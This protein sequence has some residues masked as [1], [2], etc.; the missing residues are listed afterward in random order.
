[1]ARETGL[2][3]RDPRANYPK[4][5]TPGERPLFVEILRVF[6]TRIRI[7]VAVVVLVLAV[8]VYQ[9]MRATPIYRST[10]QILVERQHSR[11][12]QLNDPLEVDTYDN[13]YYTTQYKIL[14]GPGLARQVAEYLTAK[15]METDEGDV[16]GGLEIT[17]LRNNRIFDVAYYHS[18]P[19][20]AAAVANAVVECYTAGTKRRRLDTI[21]DLR[22]EMTGELAPL[23]QKLDDSEAALQKFY[24][25]HGM[26]QGEERLSTLQRLMDETASMMVR[27]ESELRRLE[28]TSVQIE[29]AGED[30]DVLLSLDAVL[31]SVAVRDLRLEE[32]RALEE[33]EAIRKQYQP[34]SRERV[35]AETRSE[36]IT[37]KLQETARSVAKGILLQREVLRQTIAVTKTRHEELRKQRIDQ[38]VLASRA[39]SMRR[40]R[41]ANRNL[42]ETLVLRIRESEI[43]GGLE[44]TNVHVLSKAT[45]PDWA[46]RPNLGLSFMTGIIIA[47]LAACAVTLLLE[48]IDNTVRVPEDVETIYGMPLLSVVPL[49]RPD[50]S[51]VPPGIV[52][53]QDE[54]SPMAEAFRRLRAALLLSV[55]TGEGAVMKRILICSAA[56]NEGKTVCAT[57]LAIA[58]A[59]MGQRTLLIDTDFYRSETHKYFG[60]DRDK[61]L[62]TALVSDIELSQVVQPTP[63]P[64][65][66][67]LAT[68]LVPP[69]PTS[70][71]GSARMRWV[72]DE[73]ARTYDRIV[74]DTSPLV[75]V[76]DATMLAPLVDGLVMIVSQGKTPKPALRRAL[77]TLGR[78]GI[79]PLGAVFNGIKFGVSEFYF[80]YDAPSAGGPEVPAPRPVETTTH[81]SS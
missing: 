27:E 81:S 24:S 70:L 42:H 35:A 43:T 44:T 32:A 61:G 49:R 76:T 57:N 37:R 12:G 30:V 5:P 50:E 6:Q 60:L 71:L 51:N 17:W 66:D 14:Q 59:Q 47:L 33:R 64:F 13:D 55:P 56:P 38:D 2:T 34:G 36:E 22:K 7:F 74:I 58:L 15:N 62:S 10:S 77:Q 65:L 23:K 53:W 1:M 45:P 29:I 79:R 75:A 11:L 80:R 18:D 16:M 40:E 4:P 72:V 20:F 26:L 39:D 21:T 78:I 54:R 19:K 31:E 67:F 52:C 48:H 8:T 9:M 46:V 28:S 68:G 63:V 25:Q 73:A 41:D 69:Q 3:T